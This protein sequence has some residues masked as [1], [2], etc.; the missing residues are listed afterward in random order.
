MTGIPFDLADAERILAA[1]PATLDELL[2]AAPER[3]VQA[4]DGPGTWSPFDVVEH[5]IHGERTDWIARARHILEH[6]DTVAFEPFDRY[7]QV[8]ESRGRSLAELLAEFRALRVANLQALRDLALNR[9]LLDLPGLHPELG[10]VTLRQLLATWVAHDLGH[11][12]QIARTMARRYE[13]EVGAWHAYLPIL[14]R[15]GESPG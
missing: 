4:G 9:D 11:I 14:H 8:K 15:S 2:R 3:W 12:A 5:L 6:R 10:R 13:T 7:A 1:T